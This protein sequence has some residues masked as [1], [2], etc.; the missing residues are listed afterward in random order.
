MTKAKSTCATEIPLYLIPQEIT[1]L[2]RT[3]GEKVYRISIVRTHF[4]H[5]NISVRMRSLPRELQPAREPAPEVS[6]EVEGVA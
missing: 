4:H 2:I 6:D 1:R 3:R 5:Y